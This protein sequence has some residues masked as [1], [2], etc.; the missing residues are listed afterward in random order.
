MSNFLA[1]IVCDQSNGFGFLPLCCR[2]VRKESG[3]RLFHIP[4]RLCRRTVRKGSAFPAGPPL[5]VE[6]APRPQLLSMKMIGHDDVGVKTKLAGLA[7]CIERAQLIVLISSVRK[8][9][10]TIFGD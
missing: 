3:L 9:R 2:T 8:N 7:R 1:N 4:L 10:Q 6:A 5:L